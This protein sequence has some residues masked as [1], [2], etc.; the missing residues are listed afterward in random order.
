ME[1]ITVK[2]DGMACGMCESHVCDA[3]RRGAAVKRVTASHSKNEAVIVAGDGIVSDDD[4]R[5]ALDGTG[6]QVL[7]ISRTP[8]E[9]KKSFFA[10]FRK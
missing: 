3:I 9:E 5:K 6:Y 1:Q 7:S 8:Q 4:I 2:I 10:R